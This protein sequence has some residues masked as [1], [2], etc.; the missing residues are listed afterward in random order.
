MKE[1]EY[2]PLTYILLGDEAVPLKE[3]MMRPFPGQLDENEKIF[4]YRHLRGRRVVENSFGILIDSWR[5]LGK[6]IKATVENVEWYLLA[7][8]PLHDY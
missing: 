3:C 8:M 7:K 5:I 1:C 6:P 4:N 2:D